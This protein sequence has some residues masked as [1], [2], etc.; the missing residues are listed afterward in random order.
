MC[1]L[2]TVVLT[3]L[4]LFY[5]VRPKDQTERVLAV[6]LILVC[7]PNYSG[8]YCNI[9]Y[10]PAVIAFLNAEEHKKTD[11]FI[12]I[13]VFLILNPVQ[14]G[15]VALSELYL[16]GNAVLLTVMICRAVSESFRILYRKIS[17]A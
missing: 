4:L 7:M 10:I 5:C 3:T 13:A 11:L 16:L 1:V 2:L 15:I 9:Y 8:Y 12:L 17:Y 14:T 6:T